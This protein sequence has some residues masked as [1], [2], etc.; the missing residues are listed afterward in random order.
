MSTI[1][2]IFEHR[3]EIQR[4]ILKSFGKEVDIEKAVQRQVGDVHPNGKWIWTEYKPGRFDWRV[5]KKKPEKQTTDKEKT[6]RY[7]SAE[8]FIEALK[9][10]DMSNIIY[11][12]LDEKLKI[13]RSETN[14]EN[15]EAGLKALKRGREEYLKKV[16]EGVEKRDNELM[17]RNR[18]LVD[19]A[20]F[21]FDELRKKDIIARGATQKELDDFL[22]GLENKYAADLIDKDTFY[23]KLKP[24]EINYLLLKVTDYGKYKPFLTQKDFPTKKE[25]RKYHIKTDVIKNLLYRKT[26]EYPQWDS[27]E[28]MLEDFYN[29]IIK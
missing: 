2:E 7:K 23:K 1:E 14:L 25:F 17:R 4:N 29:I 9:P 6:G 16:R 24:D 22:R 10:E 12:N 21:Y 26:G 15:L 20:Q 19:E 28:S 27:F 3:K 11:M 18:E 13:F 5:I 8:E